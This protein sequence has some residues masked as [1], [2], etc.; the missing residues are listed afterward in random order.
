[1][2]LDFGP[3]AM[4]KKLTF[5]NLREVKPLLVKPLSRE[6]TGFQGGQ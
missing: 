4:E 2:H 5:L 6:D 1:M 3:G